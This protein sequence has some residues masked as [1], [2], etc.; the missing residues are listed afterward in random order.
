VLFEE[1]MRAFH[2]LF[3]DPLN[4]AGGSARSGLLRT[5]L[6]KPVYLEAAQPPSA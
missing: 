6:E 4:L 3:L 2:V 1:G 5:L